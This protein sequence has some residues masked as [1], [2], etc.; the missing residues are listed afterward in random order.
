MVILS[1]YLESQRNDL[2]VPRLTSLDSKIGDMK[3]S[4]SSSRASEFACHSKACAPPPVGK[5]GSGKSAI[6]GKD[7]DGFVGGRY[8]KGGPE[9]Y[10]AGQYGHRKDLR[11]H[12]WH[13]RCE[14]QRAKVAVVQGSKQQGRTM[15]DR[16]PYH[17]QVE[18]AN[19]EADSRV[20]LNVDRQERP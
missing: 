1:L 16:S 8:K 10:A 3:V 20:V 17:R 9:P 15:G 12:R 19:Q 13:N 5:G 6:T 18:N 7:T 2:P 11:H 14:H 4:L